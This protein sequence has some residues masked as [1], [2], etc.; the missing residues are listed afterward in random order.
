VAYS[1]EK[2]YSKHEKWDSNRF[3]YIKFTEDKE[4]YLQELG[5]RREFIFSVHNLFNY[6]KREDKLLIKHKI[7]E[8]CIN[9]DL[10]KNEALKI[11]HINKDIVFDIDI[12]CRKEC[13]IS[14]EFCSRSTFSWENSLDI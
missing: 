2:Y 9:Y 5:Y 8:F 6:C 10:F 1:W 14:F 7:P 11:L 12:L 4:N 3:L 13:C